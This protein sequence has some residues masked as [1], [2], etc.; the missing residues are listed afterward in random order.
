MNLSESASK[1]KTVTFIDFPCLNVLV[2][3]CKSPYSKI[4]VFDHFA[5]IFL[6]KTFKKIV[7]LLALIALQLLLVIHRIATKNQYV[8]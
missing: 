6:S 8:D 7:Y 5:L 4:S 3:L 1:K 2:F